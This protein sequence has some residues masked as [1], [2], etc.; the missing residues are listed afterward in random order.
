MFWMK[1]RKDSSTFVQYHKRFFI[2]STIYKELAYKRHVISK[3]ARWACFY[4]LNVG[5]GIRNEK[6]SGQVH[7]VTHIP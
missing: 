4:M 7:R 1:V 3:L 5:Q 2:P 6:K